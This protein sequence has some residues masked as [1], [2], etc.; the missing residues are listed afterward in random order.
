M[1]GFSEQRQALVDAAFAAFGDDAS[2]S[3]FAD[4]V[5]VRRLEYDDDARFGS[6]EAVVIVRFLRVRRSEVPNPAIGDEAVL[7]ETGDKFRVTGEPK[8]RRN[9][10]WSMAV[11]LVP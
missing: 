11:A 10:V 8:L 4:P 2:W 1:S 6:V 5:R 7:V 3:G 9:G